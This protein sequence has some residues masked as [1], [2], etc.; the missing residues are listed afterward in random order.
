MIDRIYSL[1]I[2]QLEVFMFWRKKRPTFIK[3]KTLT[4]ATRA[5]WQNRAAEF[6]RYINLFPL[7]SCRVV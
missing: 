2:T 6:N 4:N 7:M 1:L 3:G 5:R